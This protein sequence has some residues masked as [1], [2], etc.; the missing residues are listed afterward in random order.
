MVD[1]LDAKMFSLN[2]EIMKLE[3]SKRIEEERLRRL[4][5]EMETEDFL[6]KGKNEEA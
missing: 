6:P 2:N 3:E 1:M 5:E 4:E